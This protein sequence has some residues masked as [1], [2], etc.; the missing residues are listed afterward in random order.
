MYETA[1]GVSAASLSPTARASRSASIASEV[2]WLAFSQSTQGKQ[3]ADQVVPVVHD[4]WEV[5]GQLPL[6]VQGLLQG[7]FGLGQRQKVSKAATAIL[8]YASASSLRYW[9]RLGNSSTNR[10]N[11]SIERR[12]SLRARS[13]PMVLP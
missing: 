1:G 2:R 13:E 3:A 5:G 6:D 9:G 8:K 12:K 10:S 11:R 7:L 4:S